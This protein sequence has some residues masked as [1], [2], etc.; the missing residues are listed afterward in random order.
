V[1]DFLNGWTATGLAT[2]AISVGVALW[3]RFT[4]GRA[5]DSPPWYVRLA[6]LG[7]EALRRQ[8]AEGALDTVRDSLL[9]EREERLQWQAR[10]REATTEI[11]RLERENRE[12]RGQ[13]AL[14]HSSATTEPSAASSDGST[15]SR[16][17]K[18]RK[19]RT[20]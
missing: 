2:T 18:T 6:R 3:R 10:F 20:T 1:S 11:D 16:G 12:L 4:P 5:P 9:L 17:A 8:A 14:P 19:R 7:S 13:P 15:A